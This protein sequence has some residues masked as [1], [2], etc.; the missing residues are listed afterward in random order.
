MPSII[1]DEFNS[2]N[3]Q[4]YCLPQFE[5]SQ[6]SGL[7]LHIFA[8]NNIRNEVI[9]DFSFETSTK[10][11]DFYCLVF[12]PPDMYKD[13]F[14]YTKIPR[15]YAKKTT[16]IFSINNSQ[17]SNIVYRSLHRCI[18]HKNSITWMPESF[19]YLAPFTKCS[20][21]HKEPLILKG[22][23]APS[24]WSSADE[25]KDVSNVLTHNL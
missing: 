25:K 5:I 11:K 22:R 21:K 4:R 12:H 8:T 13:T 15:C 20:K 24:K 14:Q 17:F 16:Y 6:I 23:F 2:V 9:S 1:R 10:L 19:F 3:Y 7:S 18:L